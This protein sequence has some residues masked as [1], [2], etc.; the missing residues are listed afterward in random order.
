MPK[1][2][3]ILATTLIVASALIVAARPPRA[4][5]QTAP[6]GHGLTEGARLADVYDTILRGHSEDARTMLARTCPPAPAPACDALREVALWWEIQQDLSNRQLDAAMQAAATTAIA[7]TR[8]WT[9]REPKRGEAWFYLAGAYAPLSQWRVLRNE[10]LTAARDGIRIKDALERALALDPSLN[11]AWFGIGLYHYYADVA[12]AVLKF[13]RFLLLLP[14][15]NREQGMQEM[16][17]TRQQG[18]LLRGEADFQM[19]WLYDWYEERPDRALAL[20][21]GLA[22]TYPTNPLFAARIAEVQHVN[23]SDHQASAAT[24]RQLLERATSNTVAFAPL[25]AARARV[26]L[27]RELVDLAQPQQALDALA[28][29]LRARPSAPYGITAEAALAQGN[30]L[31]ALGDRSG[32]ATAYAQAFADAPRDDPDKVRAR[33]REG[34]S[35]LRARR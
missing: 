21:Q 23:F 2:P 30:A 4:F 9:A 34:Q 10:K 19:H 22:T 3:A 6:S 14:G 29:V 16:L 25:T 24:W 15:G 13:L 1:L 12:P 26:G 18:Q 8:A 27:A 31:A 28:P 7:S 5:A 17:R 11:D 20:L 35:K 33:V 32:A